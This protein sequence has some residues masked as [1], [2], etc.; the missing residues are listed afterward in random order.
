MPMVLSQ[1]IAEL[2]RLGVPN[3]TVG[4]ISH[5][6]QVGHVSPVHKDGLGYRQ[7][8]Q[9]HVDELQ[10]YLSEPRRRGRPRTV[11]SAD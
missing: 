9:H 5:G 8:E 3:P 6:I 2:K 4:K 11:S 1:V 10:R 7:F